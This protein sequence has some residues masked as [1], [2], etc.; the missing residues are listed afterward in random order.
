MSFS[1]DSV[2]SFPN[3]RKSF[4]IDRRSSTSFLLL[5]FSFSRFERSFFSLYSKLLSAV[6]SFPLFILI[7]RM[8][9][10]FVHDI[11][12]RTPENF[13]CSRGTLVRKRVNSL[14]ITT[15]SLFHG[16]SVFWGIKKIEREK[17][18]DNK[19]LDAIPGRIATTCCI[20]FP[21]FWNHSSFYFFLPLEE[22]CYLYLHI[23]RMFVNI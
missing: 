17:N 19:L 23:V 11:D 8:L 15:E 16:L 22:S 20:F 6:D 7:S 13:P 4:Q 5:L 21:R 12:I 1:M 18:R 9:L 3:R 10:R 2:F 14:K